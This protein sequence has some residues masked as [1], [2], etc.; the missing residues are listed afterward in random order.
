MTSSDKH[1]ATIQNISLEVFLS[2]ENWLLIYTAVW[3]ISAYWHWCNWTAHVDVRHYLPKAVHEINNRW[4]RLST[5]APRLF[6]L[7]LNTPLIIRLCFHEVFILSWMLW[8]IT[9]CPL[10]T[11]SWHVAARMTPC[12]S[13]CVC[14][15]QCLVEGQ[16]CSDKPLKIKAIG[17]CRCGIAIKDYIK[18]LDKPSTF[19]IEFWSEILTSQIHELWFATI[20]RWYK[21]EGHSQCKKAFH[22]TK[23]LTRPWVQYESSHFC[24]VLSEEKDCRF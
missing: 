10:K 5:V 9:N 13:V 22:W 11:V 17:W 14:E 6:Y 8:R 3:R 20:G 16:N 12:L 24:F 15:A 1:K 23:M 21:E 7:P 2:A 18:W 19:S 4:P